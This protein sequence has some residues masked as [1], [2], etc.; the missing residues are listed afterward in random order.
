[1]KN[2]IRNVSHSSRCAPLSTVNFAIK[3]RSPPAAM[4]GTGSSGTI[5]SLTAWLTAIRQLE[6]ARKKCANNCRASV[7]D[8]ELMGHCIQSRRFAESSWREPSEMDGKVVRPSERERVS[9]NALQHVRNECAPIEWREII[10]LF[11][12]A[13]KTR[14]DSK[15]VLD[16][17]DDATFAAAVELGDDNTGQSNGALEFAR[18]AE[19]VAA[20]RR[21]DHEQFFMR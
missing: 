7:S 1:M 4:G 3:P 19:R 20:S 12:G 14:W 8:A 21:I 2:L 16:C 5:A 18:L 6:H 15:F 17:D 9:Q 10:Q 11:A 13:D